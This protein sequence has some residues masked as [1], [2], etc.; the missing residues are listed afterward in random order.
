MSATASPDSLARLIF[1]ISC[2]LVKNSGGTS[3]P[4]ANRH[5]LGIILAA[6]VTP[7]VDIRAIAPIIADSSRASINPISL[8]PSLFP[9][10]KRK[11]SPPAAPTADKVD[12]P[13]ICAP[14]LTKP[15]GKRL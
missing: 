15:A 14:R 12:N 13:N 5:A 6:V 4:V 8:Y 1:K 10:A 7:A 3:L 9:V 11:K 2:I